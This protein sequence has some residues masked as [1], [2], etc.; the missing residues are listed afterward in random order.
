MTVIWGGEGK[1]VFQKYFPAIKKCQKNRTQIVRLKLVL[2]YL[3]IG[4]FCT[5]SSWQNDEGVLGRDRTESGDRERVLLLRP[6]LLP[7]PRQNHPQGA[8]RPRRA[9]QLRVFRP[10]STVKE[11]TVTVIQ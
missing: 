3:T 11:V 10:Y 8:Q 1:T 9:H 4:Q 2:N 7:R 6:A 5:G